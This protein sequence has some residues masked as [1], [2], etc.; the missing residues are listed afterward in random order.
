MADFTP[1]EGLV[2][3]ALI[4]LSAAYLLVMNGR[5]AGIS[6]IFGGLLASFGEQ[7]L[8]R[9]AFVVGLIAG[10]ALTA[11]LAPGLAPKITMSTN[12]LVLIGGG[13][14]V[15][16]GTRVG[17]GCTSGHGVC[18]ISRFS[19]RGIVA[20]LVYLVAGGITMY[21]ARHILGVI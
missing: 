14:L 12:V 13:L 20:T 3:G 1:I 4:G 17:N 18:G 8:W 5:V 6:G 10:A 15:G 11:A 9:I 2:G 7:S 19:T 16:I 21:V